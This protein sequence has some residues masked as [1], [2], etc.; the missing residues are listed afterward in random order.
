MWVICEIHQMQ[1]NHEEGC[2]ACARAAGTRASD[3]GS[4]TGVKLD[5]G[6][7]QVGLMLTDFSH[8][9]LA[10][11]EV[12]VAE[13]AGNRARARAVIQA[14]R[15][16]LGRLSTVRALVLSLQVFAQAKKPCSASW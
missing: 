16:N 7:P 10:V 4:R 15:W 5:H 3:C 6:K 2:P 13:V 9:L 12:V 1:Y 8:A 14:W 11:A